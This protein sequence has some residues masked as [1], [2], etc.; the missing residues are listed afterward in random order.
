MASSKVDLARPQV[1]AAWFRDSFTTERPGG[2]LRNWC[3]VG[4]RFW[5]VGSSGR[6]LASNLA[7]L[8]AEILEC[9]LDG[10]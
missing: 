4:S 3:P 1:L 10:A 8:G 2:R 7:H 5:G 6:V 9:L